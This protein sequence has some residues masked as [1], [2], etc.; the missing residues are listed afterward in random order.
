MV[1]VALAILGS[2]TALT[3]TVPDDAGRL[4]RRVLFLFLRDVE[5]L[6]TKPFSFWPA[7]F[8]QICQILSLDVVGLLVFLVMPR[9][10]L[11]HR[12]CCLR[13]LFSTLVIES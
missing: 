4:A 8:S 13:A 11:R 2:V 5:D 10:Q 12:A 6:P 9:H 1:L 3:I 7:R